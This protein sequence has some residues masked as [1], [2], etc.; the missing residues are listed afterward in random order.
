[1]RSSS[2]FVIMKYNDDASLTY[3]CNNNKW[4]KNNKFDKAKTRALSSKI[5]YNSGNA[6]NAI[7]KLVKAKKVDFKQLFVW[8]LNGLTPFT[9]NDSISF[10]MIQSL[11]TD[12]G[13]LD[14]IASEALQEKTEQIELLEEMLIELRV[15]GI[16]GSED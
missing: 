16:Q 6:W 7:A 12:Q 9:E 1:M 5:W 15:A 2:P 4:T 3:L 8:S 13:E 14:A 10:S 11:T